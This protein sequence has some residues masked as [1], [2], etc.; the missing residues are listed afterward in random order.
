MNT[1]KATR[2]TTVVFYRN[3]ECYRVKITFITTLS[4]PAQL[5]IMY[6]FLLPHPTTPNP[7][8]HSTRCRS[9]G[10]SQQ[11]KNTTGTLTATFS[12]SHL[13]FLPFRAHFS[14]RSATSELSFI[15]TFSLFLSPFHPWPSFP[16]Y[17]HVRRV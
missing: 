11:P 16:A 3:A 5:C 13:H 9:S 14:H 15:H 4:S 1:L 6:P 8:V 12:F 10:Y 7:V 17:A 2:T